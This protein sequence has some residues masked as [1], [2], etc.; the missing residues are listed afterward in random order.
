ML[1]RRS[2]HRIVPISDLHL[3]KSDR[4]PIS[5]AEGE[6]LILAG[7]IGNPFSDNYAQFLQ[8]LVKSF[9][10]IICISGNHEYWNSEGV[11]QTERQLRKVAAQFKNVHY[12]QKDEVVLDGV[13]YLG[14]TLWA[15]ADRRY[16]PRDLSM[17]PGMD[18]DRYLS[19]HRDHRSWLVDR[20]DQSPLP[21]VV[22]THHLPSYQMIH[23][24]YHSYPTLSY[25]ASNLDALIPKAD[26]WI[27]GHSH[28]AM[29][30]RFGKTLCLSNPFGYE[31]E[32]TG[33][34]DRLVIERTGSLFKESN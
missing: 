8:R 6:T 20:L 15:D 3:E 28:T 31:G 16:R 29:K 14:C 10:H 33:F 18:Y 12:L 22:V 4:R 26:L 27:C 17:I 7:D 11:A 24:K 9:Q 13:R 30:K 19:L 2:L 34:N 21:T 25:Y 1:L 23:P 5:P 32:E